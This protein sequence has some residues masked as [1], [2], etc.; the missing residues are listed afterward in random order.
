[1]KIICANLDGKIQRYTLKEL[2][3][4]AFEKFNENPSTD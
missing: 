4:E 2:F 3:P 1:L